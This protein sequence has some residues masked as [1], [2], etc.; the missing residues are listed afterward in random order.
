MILQPTLFDEPLPVV[1]ACRDIKRRQT[2]RDR[3]LNI[4]HRQ[5]YITLS[6]LRSISA[7]HT[8]RI[9]ELR[10]WLYPHGKDLKLINRKPSGETVYGIVPLEGET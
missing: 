6:Q 9:S 3:I 4:L 7:N 10:N 5:K 2:H 8:A 1:R